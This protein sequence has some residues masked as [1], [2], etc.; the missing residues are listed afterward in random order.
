MQR[1]QYLLLMFM[2]SVAILYWRRYR[3][4]TADL[5]FLILFCVLG[6]LFILFP[7]RSTWLANLVGVGRGADLLLYTLFCVTFLV[8]S[9]HKAKIEDAEER[10]AK[11][12]RHLALMEAPD[13]SSAWTSGDATPPSAR[14]TGLPERLLDD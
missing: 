9:R 1:V 5:L 12:V 4:R 14:T 10:I 8:L 6:A 11:L 13:A 2:A 7:E 3:S